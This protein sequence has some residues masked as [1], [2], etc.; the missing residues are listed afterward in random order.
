MKNAKIV[1]SEAKA[2][3]NLRKHGVSFHDASEVFDVDLRLEAVQEAHDEDG[4]RFVSVAPL[5]IGFVTVVWAEPASNVLRIISAR[6][7]TKR[8]VADYRRFIE[9]RS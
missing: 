2:Q 8:E 6:R 1:W 9:G 3:D 4:Y 7:A 5:S